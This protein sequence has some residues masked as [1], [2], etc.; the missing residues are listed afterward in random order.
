MG[1]QFGNFMDDPFLFDNQAFGISPREASSMDPQQRVML[2]TVHRALENAGYVADSTPSFAR[3]TFGCFIGNA[4]LD[5]VDNLRNNIDVYYSPGTLRAFLSGRISYAFK[6]SGPS[7]TVDT[8]CSSSLVAIHQAARALAAGECRAA[9]AGGVNVITSPDMYLGLERAHFLS[10]TGQCK[11]FDKSADGYCRSEGCAAVVLKRLSDAV[12]END[13]ILGVIKGIAV[14]QSGQASSITH[15]H[16][17]TQEKLFH[18]V[19]SKA[20]MRHEDVSVVEAHGTGTPAGDPNEV[21]GIRNVFCKG[22]SPE[23]PLHI[24]SIKANIGHCEAASGVASLTKLLLMLKHKR[25]PPQ[26]LLNELNPAI[27]DLAADGTVISTESLDWTPSRGKRRTALLNNF[28]AAGSNAALLIQEYDDTRKQRPGLGDNAIAYVFGCSARNAELLQQLRGSLVSYLTEHQ[29]ELSIADVCYTSTARRSLQSHRFSTTASSIKD[30][31]VNLK[32]AQILEVPESPRATVFLFSG[33]GS[34]YMGMGRRLM[35]LSPRFSATVHRCHRLLLEW[36]LPSCLDVIQPDEDKTYQPQDPTIL[37]A[38]Q[39]GVFVLEVAV[40]QVLMDAG[41]RPLIVSGHSLGEYAALVT[42][43][44]LDLESGLW[45]VAQRARLIIGS[46]KLWETSML[47]VSMSATQVQQDLLSRSEFANLTIS[48]ENSPG[49]CVVGGDKQ[50]LMVL[51]D[52]VSVLGRKSKMLNVPIAYHTAALGQIAEDIRHMASQVCLSAPAI[53][54]TS[55]VLGRVVQ[56]GEQVFTPDYFAQHCCKKVAFDSG[57][58]DILTQHD[59]LFHGR[60]LEIGPHPVLLPMVSQ[61]SSVRERFD[62]LILASGCLSTTRYC[63]GKA[64]NFEERP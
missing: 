8:A 20:G 59:N 2:T 58:D 29:S 30:L 54:V 39:T 60:W 3:E 53:P 52:H 14:N 35:D 41:I 50:K 55:N 21:R 48:C 38:L 32:D 18:E 42:A 40:A 15:P 4:T 26:A 36:G 5:Y 49:D 64:G 7:I 31:I 10:P 33:Q 17:P 47:A 24:M 51:K 25:I 34:Q 23:N 45:L 19:L 1:T 57:L 63:I 12:N 62:L 44:V 27:P 56:P 6:W 9:V 43:G 61:K 16:A 28:G 37:Q 46:C 22:R 11:A 13:N